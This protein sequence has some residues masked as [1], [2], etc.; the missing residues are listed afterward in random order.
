MVAAATFLAL[1]APKLRLLQVVAAIALVLMLGRET[2]A[3]GASWSPYYKIELSRVTH[4]LVGLSVNGVPHQLIEPM[5]RRRRTEPLYFVPYERIRNN[6]LNDVLI[7]GA[8]SG[9]D[10]A[11]ALAHGAKHVDAV[12]IDPRICA[13][14]RQ[15]PPRPPVSGSARQLHIDDGRAFVEAERSLRSR[16]LS[17]ARL[18][19]AR[20]G[21]SSL[22]LES[23]LFTTQAMRP[24]R[25]L[26]KPNGA[27]GMYNYY[28]EDW[29]KDVTPHDRGSSSGSAL[30]VDAV[31]QAGLVS[32]RSSSA[33]GK[34]T[35]LQHHVERG[36]ES[37]TGSGIRRSPFPYLRTPSI[38]PLYLWTI[39]LILLV[40]WPAIRFAA[41]P[42]GE[43]RG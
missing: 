2:F 27:F 16:F 39:G 28:R 33:A 10:V 23:Y 21:Q 7:I 42:L 31:G 18:A 12:E 17:S 40:C 8:G 6:P 3:P 26:L 5:S 13:I 36:D 43:M 37:D 32:R 22:R 4:D 19:R 25:D 41:G 20:F 15:I 14:G 1:Y 9:S 35:R 38:P 34:A 29:L 11:I 24:V 30:V